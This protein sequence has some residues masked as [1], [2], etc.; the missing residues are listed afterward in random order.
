[1]YVTRLDKSLHHRYLLD[2][3]SIFLISAEMVKKIY[4]SHVSLFKK[5]FYRIEYSD[6]SSPK[7]VVKVVFSHPPFY[8]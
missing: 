6:L 1:M 2:N 7:V 5:L 4:D 8:L 3:T